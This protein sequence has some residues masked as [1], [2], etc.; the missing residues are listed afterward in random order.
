M[1][2]KNSIKE[3]TKQISLVKVSKNNMHAQILFELLEKRITKISH[4]VQPS[5]TQHKDFVFNNPYRKWFLI[6]QHDKFIGSVY[7]LKN[8]SIGINIISSTKI[9]MPIVINEL[10]SKYK[11]L[12]AI[13]SVRTGGFDFNV[14]PNN[15][16]YIKILEGMGAN[17]AQLTY[18]FPPI[19][20]NKGN[21]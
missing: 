7:I 15:R 1:N 11:P 2:I 16:Q 14:S 12:K 6:K 4:T 9:A 17:L 20:V 19:S 5:Y 13:K 18:T 21:V 3:K 10:L 8:N